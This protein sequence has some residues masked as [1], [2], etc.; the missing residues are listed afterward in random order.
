MNQ[1]NYRIIIELLAIN[2]LDKF[3]FIPDFTF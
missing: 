1:F 3:S 2:S